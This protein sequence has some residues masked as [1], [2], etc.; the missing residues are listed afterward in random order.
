MLETILN[1][2]AL[3]ELIGIATILGIFLLEDAPRQQRSEPPNFRP[4]IG[5]RRPISPIL[6][7]TAVP[8]SE[9]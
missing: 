5:D 7:G 6:T 3:A 4:Y 8:E 9:P 1:C 2:V